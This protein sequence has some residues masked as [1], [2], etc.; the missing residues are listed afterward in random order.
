MIIPSGHRLLVKPFKQEET[1]EI[2]RKAKE[3]GFL[4]SFEI[5][6]SNK[7]RE[8]ASVDSGI[9]VSVGPD[10]W[11]NSKEPWCAVGDTI[12]FAKFAPKFVKDLDGT[13]YGILND[14]DVVAVIKEA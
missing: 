8:D 10:C 4:D 9:V 13:D 12:Y 7:K 2:L 11:P 6:N 14:E 1:D 3:S 5:V